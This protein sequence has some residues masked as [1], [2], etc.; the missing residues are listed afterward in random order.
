M[1][2]H[3]GDRSRAVIFND[4]ATIRVMISDG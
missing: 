3:K 1:T 2:C 4:P